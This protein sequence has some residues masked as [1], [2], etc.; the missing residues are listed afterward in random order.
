[1]LV[2]LVVVS[3][4]EMDRK[5][6]CR[7]MKFGTQVVSMQK[8]PK[9]LGQVILISF[10]SCYW[11][12]LN[13]IIFLQKWT[14][15]SIKINHFNMSLLLCSNPNNLKWNACFKKYSKCPCFNT[16]AQLHLYFSSQR[17]ILMRSQ[18]I[19]RILVSI[20]H[21]CIYCQKLSK[22]IW[23]NQYDP[24]HHN[25]RSFIRHRVGASIFIRYLKHM[26]ASALD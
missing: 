14:E 16:S 19:I 15:S 25:L 21:T 13:S 8:W 4:L 2:V 23:S 3:A 11:L 7:V 18:N 1:M 6:I 20:W 12:G 17:V 22:H 10:Y 26:F 9:I 5:C 24:I